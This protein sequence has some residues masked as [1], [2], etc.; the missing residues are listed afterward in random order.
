MRNII[1]RKIFPLVA[2]REVPTLP[3]ASGAVSAWLTA[4][5]WPLARLP[6]HAPADLVRS[7][8][9]SFSLPETSVPRAHVHNVLFCTYNLYNYSI[10]NTFANY[11][12]HKLWFFIPLH[13]SANS[14]RLCDYSLHHIKILVVQQSAKYN[15]YIHVSMYLSICFRDSRILH[16]YKSGFLRSW[17]PF[18][19]L[20]E[21]RT[22]A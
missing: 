8:Q 19:H 4:G 3:L 13:G 10:I 2:D 1:F 21:Y 22:Y 17:V 6:H 16:N 5:L 15:I 20:K 11:S 14:Y 7:H 12:V 9:A 18:C